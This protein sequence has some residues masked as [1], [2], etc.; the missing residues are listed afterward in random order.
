M[1]DT[2]NYLSSGLTLLNCGLTDN[3]YCAFKKGLYNLIAGDSMSGKTWFAMQLFAEA[4]HDESFKDHK[5]IFDQP[6]DGALMDV[7]DFFGQETADRIVPASYDEDGD[8]SDSETLEEMY[9]LA[10]KAFRKGPC[11]EFVDSHDALT[12]LAEMDKAEKI[13]AAVENDTSVAGIMSDGKAKVNSAGLRLLKKPLK[14]HGSIF[15]MISQL[16]DNLGFGFEKKSRSGGRALRFYASTEIW[17]T[18][19]KTITK[20][21]KGKDREI[22]NMISIKVKK[23]RNSSQRPTV[24]VPLIH[25]YGFDDVGSCVDWLRENH[26]KGEKKINCPE[27]STTPLSREDLIALI[28]EKLSRYEKLKRLVGKVWNEIRS[29]MKPQRKKRYG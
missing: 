5:L 6:E 8:P 9:S 12:C 28:E 4:A 3:P 11:I 25:D 2:D 26:W 21:V 16:R 7:A 10:K 13:D 22:G 29:N 27:F 23:N 14:A 20:K 17:F 18:P 19:I 1:I 24:I 15:F